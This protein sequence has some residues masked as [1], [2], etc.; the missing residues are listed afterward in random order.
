MSVPIHYLDPDPAGLTAMLGGILE[1][2]L[3]DHPERA[4]LLSPPMVASIRVPD[5]GTEVSLRF[6][7]ERIQVRTGPVSRP[8]VV[9]QADSE[10]LMSLSTVPL[11]FGLPDLGTKDGRHVIGQLLRRKL[12]IKGALWHPGKLARLNKLLSVG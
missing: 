5:A 7:A 3:K 9:V 12:R 1:G 10:M 4:R 6:T 2:N 11:R 8:D